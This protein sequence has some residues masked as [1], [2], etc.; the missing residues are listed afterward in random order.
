[1][2]DV[3]NKIIVYLYKLNA[4]SRNYAGVIKLSTK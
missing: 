3:D 1:M 4:D 2:E